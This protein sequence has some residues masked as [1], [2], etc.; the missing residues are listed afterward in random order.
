MK[1]LE[2]LELLDRIGRALQDRMTFADIDIYLKAKG[3]DT[4]KDWS[5]TNS[6]W[7]YSKEMLA[8][9]S[10]ALIVEI[11]DDLEIPH[12]YATVPGEPALVASFWEPGQFRLFLSHL[13]DHKKSVAALQS[14]LEPYGISAFVAH[15]DIEPTKEWL[16]EIEAA[17]ASMDAM[18]AILHDGF[19]ESN[20]TDQEVGYA[21]GRGVLVLPLIRDINP[22]GFLGKYQGLHVN[23]KNVKQIAQELFWI[24]AMAP[25]TRTKMLTCLTDSA[26]RSTTPAEGLAKLGLLLS[27]TDLSNAYLERMRDGASSSLVFSEGS[28]LDALNSALGE[29]G[30]SPVFLP[31]SPVNDFDI[32]F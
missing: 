27:V 31:A 20:W 6:K 22:Y 8:D 32:P 16:D 5:G 25:K 1:T 28:A 12:T 3:V 24:L 14:A 9:E 10:E 21:M 13:S 2:R 29:R 26:L 7:V 4:S 11:A 19:K 18:A 17:L 15:V 30:L 23:G